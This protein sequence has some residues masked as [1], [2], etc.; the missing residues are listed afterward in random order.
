VSKSAPGVRYAEVYRETSETRVQ[1]VM[2]LD[3]GSRQD[4]STGLG[5]FDHMLTQLAF[6]GQVDLGISVEGDLK[7]D[8][9]HTVEDVGIVLGQAFHQALDQDHGIG[10]YGDNTTA[11]DEALILVALDVSGR[12]GLFY[13]VTW[14]R[15]QIGDLATEN[16]KEFLRAFTSHA[17]VTL[18]VKKLAGDNDHHVCEGIFKALG[19]AIHQATTVTERRGSSS[20]KGSRD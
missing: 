16:V 19:R 6:H 13:D 10:R 4:I 17:H 12:S 14:T 20:T 8:D 5:F 15:E 11:M 1:V 3:G 18:H 7:I 2:D 9:H